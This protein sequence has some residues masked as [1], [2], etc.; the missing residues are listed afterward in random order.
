[1][2]L[3][4]T[5]PIPRCFAEHPKARGIVAEA[6]IG[7]HRRGRLRAKLLIFKTTATLRRFWSKV[8]GKG[9]LDLHCRGAVNGLGYDS[10]SFRK[11]GKPIETMH[12]DPNY[13]CLIGLV[14]GFVTAEIISHE[15]VH[16]GFSYEKRVRRNTWGKAA[17]FDEER[18]A[19]PSG[20]VAGAITAFARRKGLL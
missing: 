3:V 8:L 15:S 6:D 2:R 16:A 4:H 13:F 9:D 17:D 1:M 12:A 19:Y 14:K 5:K 7:I 18:I 20:A 11:P 10:L